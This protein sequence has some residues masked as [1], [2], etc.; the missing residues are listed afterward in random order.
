MI[1]WV[2]Y[3]LLGAAM[4][5][6]GGLFGI[7]GGLIAIPALGVLFGLEQQLAQGTALVMMVPNIVLALWRYHQR[8]RVQWR[9][10]LPLVLSGFVFAWLGSLLAVGLDARSMRQG[11]VVFLLMLAAF[12]GVQMFGTRHTTVR[13]LNQPWPRMASLGAVCGM[14]GGIFG[15]GSGVVLTPVLTGLFGASQVVAQGLALALAVPSSAITLLTYAVHQHVDWSIGLPMA[16]GGLLSVSWG[17]KLAYALPQRLL[18]T[19]FCI[20]LLLCAALLAVKS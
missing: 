15:V 9:Q 18:R 5:T 2:L 20:F 16:L 4:G 17:V 3:V 13:E 12:N 6:L 14:L 11:F 7:G 8:T 1:D 10:A 19:L